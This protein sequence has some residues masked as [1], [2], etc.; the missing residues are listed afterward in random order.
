MLSCSNVVTRMTVLPYFLTSIPL[1]AEVTFARR[2]SPVLFAPS[3][4][5]GHWLAS[6]QY[7]NIRD[8]QRWSSCPAMEDG[9]CW[10]LDLFLAGVLVRCCRTVMPMPL[11]LSV[12]SR[13]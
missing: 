1:S 6:E 9:R 12:M 3:A 8:R 7:V 11:H 2:P 5:C 13:G 10:M 4:A